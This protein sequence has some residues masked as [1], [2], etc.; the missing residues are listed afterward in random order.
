MALA[1]GRWRAGR[2]LERGGRRRSVVAV[3][4]VHLDLVVVLLE[5]IVVLLQSLLVLLLLLGVYVLVGGAGLRWSASAATTPSFRHR[6][7]RQFRHPAAAA[8]GWPRLI[9]RSWRSS[10]WI[11]RSSPRIRCGNR[12]RCRRSRCGLTRIRRRSWHS[13]FRPRVRHPSLFGSYDF[14]LG[15]PRRYRPCIRNFCSL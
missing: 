15:P 10:R 7:L 5:L 3:V 1:A 4:A 14:A 2:G 11:G 9:R 13:R 8:S 12:G 6:Y